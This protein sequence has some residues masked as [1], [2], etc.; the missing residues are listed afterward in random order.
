MHWGWL[1][2]RYAEIAH[3]PEAEQRALVGAAQ[4]RLRRS[5]RYWLMAMIHSLLPLAIVAITLRL[6]PSSSMRT[7]MA[8]WFGWAAVL[9]GAQVVQTRV[10]RYFMRRFIR[11]ALL[12]QGVRPACCFD[13]GYD[14]RSVDGDR[15]P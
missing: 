8:V 11:D 3:L 9:V 1:V 12:A 13:C 10:R 14:L 5:A 7:A 15:C 6:P 4:H 2:D